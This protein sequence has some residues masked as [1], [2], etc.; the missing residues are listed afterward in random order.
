M[1]VAATGHRPDKLGGYSSEVNKKLTMFAVGILEEMKSGYDSGLVVIS[2][3]A[4][5]WDQA[6]AHAAIITKTPF[7]AAVPFAG[8]E[9]MWP[10]KGKQR[11]HK[12][13]SLAQEVVVVS[14]GG[15]SRDKMMDRNRWMVNN[16]DAMLALF[17]G[18]RG[19]TAHCVDYAKLQE[20][21]ILN[22]WEQWESY[23]WRQK[24]GSAQNR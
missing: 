13:L 5:G 22:V 21:Q 1:R 23:D 15:F 24:Y 6:V 2:G 16:A 18:S 20:V 12:I 4:Q 7:I 14:E 10:F 11:Y 9:S 3:M 19:G 8:Q 17:D